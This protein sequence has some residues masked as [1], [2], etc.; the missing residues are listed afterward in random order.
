MKTIEVDSGGAEVQGGGGELP[1]NY[2][3]F[4]RVEDNYEP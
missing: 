1:M 2:V 4:R 3:D